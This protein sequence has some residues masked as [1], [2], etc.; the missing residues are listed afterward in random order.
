MT[1]GQHHRIQ[2]PG[3]AFSA[4]ELAEI[5]G[6]TIDSIQTDISRGAPIL[7]RGGRGSQHQIPAGDFVRWKIEQA[8]ATVLPGDLLTFEA[9]RTKKMNADAAVAVMEMEE[10]RGEL[11]EVSAVVAEVTELFSAVKAHLLALPSKLAHRLA[12]AGTREAAM[13]ILENEITNAL[14]EL[15][16]EAFDTRPN[17]E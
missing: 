5:L 7:K 9:A 15:S 4:S 3:R 14:S 8:A 11:V 10:K 1:S 2:T 13:A 17:T 12:A 6:V 16:S